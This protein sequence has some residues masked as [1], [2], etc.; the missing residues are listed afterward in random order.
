MAELMRDAESVASPRL[1]LRKLDNAP[2]SRDPESRIHT[3]GQ[4]NDFGLVPEGCCDLLNRN[5][6]IC[7]RPSPQKLLR[8]LPAEGLPDLY[9]FRGWLPP[10]LSVS[11]VHSSITSSTKL[12]ATFLARR[13]FLSAPNP[14]SESA[15]RSPESPVVLPRI[16]SSSP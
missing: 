15:R 12:S 3:V 7:D 8:C 11:V 16:R 4:V 13:G 2:L 5:W 9:S 10:A 14:V 1:T 6:W